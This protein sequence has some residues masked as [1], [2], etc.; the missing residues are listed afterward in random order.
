MS[1]SVGQYQDMGQYRELAGRLASLMQAGPERAAALNQ[2]IEAVAN[3]QLFTDMLIAY[4]GRWFN[5]TGGASVLLGPE[6]F[7]ALSAPDA[8]T[9]NS[10][11]AEMAA[12]AEISGG[13]RNRKMLLICLLEHLAQNQWQ[14]ATAGLSEPRIVANGLV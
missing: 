11:A 1:S 9:G 14:T 10:I 12:Y 8:P 3:P 13:E 7:W 2:F 5:E 6:M 4:A